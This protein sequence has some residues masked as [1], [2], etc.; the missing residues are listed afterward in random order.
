MKSLKV[1]LFIYC[2]CYTTSLSGQ[3]F[4]RYDNGLVYDKST[5]TQLHIIVDS[6]NNEYLQCS[7]RPT[8][9]SLP[10]ARVHVL[11]SDQNGKA[12]EAAI[13]RGL[14][15]EALKAEFP[16]ATE[17]LN[18]QAVR[19]LD[20]DDGEPIKEYYVF[21]ALGRSVLT[22]K[23]PIYTSAPTKSTWLVSRYNESI[24]AA[25]FTEDLS[26]QALPIQYA[27][28]ISYSDCMVDTTEQI[29]RT[30][31]KYEYYE[32][33]AN[34]AAA[35]FW[36]DWKGPE[37]SPNRE[38]FKDAQKYYMAYYEYDS[39]KM[40]ALEKELE[41]NNQLKQK[42]TDVVDQVLAK[43]GSNERF[44]YITEQFISADKALELKRNRKVMGSCSQDSR[45]RDHALEIARL[46]AETTNWSVFLRSHLNLMNDRFERAS[47]GSYAW[48][49][50]MTYMKE[51]ESLE[52]D[53]VGLLVGISLRYQN[54]SENHYY[55][56]NYRIGRAIAE[57]KD[58]QKHLETIYQGIQ[59][60]S[61]DTY[62]R[63]LLS[64]LVLNSLRSNKDQWSE[65][66][67]AKAREAI[68]SLPSYLKDPMLELLE[69]ED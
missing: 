2:L 27:Q 33:S 18:L 36:E 5:M 25:Y 52:I 55:G 63:M 22:V 39:L 45:P 58:P 23:R 4:R 30:E 12:I 44:E 6:L 49:Q 61:L 53:M 41:R 40:K 51:L 28:M 3:E 38:D 13:K 46:S 68:G 59:D 56:S 65:T 64:Y 8:Y 62:N 9:Y 31:A 15:F 21:N 43:G 34:S 29:F 37:K 1:V 10:Q 42:L 24:K 47:D 35:K 16:E 11:K 69:E 60:E 50:R 14:D 54:A 26:S 57:A 7:E 19:F 17:I 32:G 48:A 67:Y 66:D 20:E